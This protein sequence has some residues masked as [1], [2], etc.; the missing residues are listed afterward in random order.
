MGAC[1]CGRMRVGG[2]F[3]LER[4]E[5]LNFIG[6]FLDCRWVGSVVG[7]FNL[8][9]VGEYCYNV[10]LA[11]FGGGETLVFWIFLFFNANF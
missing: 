1:G 4:R 3:F 7:F 11:A 5:W 8:L 10:G 9:L 6:M 2:F